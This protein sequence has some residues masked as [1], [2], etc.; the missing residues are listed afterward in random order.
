MAHV[1]VS[2]GFSIMINQA[3][4]TRSQ[5][6]FL[7]NSFSDTLSSGLVPAIKVTIYLA[8]REGCF[9]WNK[10]S[11]FQSF[12]VCNNSLKVTIWS[13]EQINSAVGAL[14]LE[15]SKLLH[16]FRFFLRL[17]WPFYPHGQGPF[18][19]R[20]LGVASMAWLYVVKAVYYRCLSLR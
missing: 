18:F 8:T 19:S 9:T 11:I 20:L 17:S 5:P 6:V 10:G 16:F 15:T 4:K 3:W 14:S 13:Q 2:Q 12:P 1:C 7:S